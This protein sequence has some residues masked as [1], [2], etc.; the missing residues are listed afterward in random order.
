[1]DLL[2]SDSNKETQDRED[3]RRTEIHQTDKVVVV[4]H[5][6]SENVVEHEHIE[7]ENLTETPEAVH[8]K[9][10]YLH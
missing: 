3:L 2:L 7:V 9:M 4:E 10:I 5:V 6:I 8:V 1:M